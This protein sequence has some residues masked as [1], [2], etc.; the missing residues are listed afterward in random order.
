MVSKSLMGVCNLSPISSL[1][2]P[3]TVHILQALQHTL[4]CSDFSPYDCA[5]LAA[6]LALAFFAFSRVGEFT[7]SHHSLWR[8]VCQLS[9]NSLLISFHSFKFSQG[10]FPHILIPQSSDPLCPVKNSRQYL[11]LRSTSAHPQLILDFQ[12]NPISSEQFRRV[13]NKVSVLLHASQ[14]HLTSQFSTW[15]CCHGGGVGHSF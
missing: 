10:S 13:L 6:M 3:I 4:Y 1:W 2:P 11:K 12:G 14:L 9:P 8:S 15:C 5:S 7:N